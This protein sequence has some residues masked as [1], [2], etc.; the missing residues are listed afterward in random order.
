MEE[1]VAANRGFQSTFHP[2]RYLLREKKQV[3]NSQHDR[4]V[5][6][7]DCGISPSAAGEQQRGGWPGLTWNQTKWD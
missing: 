2:S 7:E 1:V 4:R 5:A 3:H 6:E